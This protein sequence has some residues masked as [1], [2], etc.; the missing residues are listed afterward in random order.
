VFGAFASGDNGMLKK[1]RKN[2]AP[3]P[4]GG[5]GGAEKI[6]LFQSAS[7]VC[8][9]CAI[10]HSVPLVDT[11]SVMLNPIAQSGVNP[12]LPAIATRFERFQNIDIKPQVHLCLVAANGAATAFELAK[13]LVRQ[14]LI[15][16]I[17][18]GGGGNGRIFFV[19][20]HRK[21]SP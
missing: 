13:L 16:R 4:F 18:Q 15:V 12:C 2:K 19:G 6:F 5:R 8:A 9:W 10:I 1:P 21:N 17:A 3:A 20:R 14:W 7:S 11:D